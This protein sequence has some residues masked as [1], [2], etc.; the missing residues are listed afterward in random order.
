[1]NIIVSKLIQI[2]C[3]TSKIKIKFRYLSHFYINTDNIFFFY[4]IIEQEFST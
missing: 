4:T 1:M 2:V 3:Y